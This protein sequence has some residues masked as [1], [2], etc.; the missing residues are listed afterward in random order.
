MAQLMKQSRQAKR[1]KE[2]KNYVNKVYS[3]TEAECKES[4]K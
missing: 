2:M 1:E 4:Y 3:K